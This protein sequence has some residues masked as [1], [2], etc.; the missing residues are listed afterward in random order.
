MDETIT[1]FYYE[2]I[3]AQI[4]FYENLL[5]LEKTMD[6]DWVKIYRITTSSSVGIVQQG[7]GYHDVSA[8]KPAMLSIVTENVDAWYERLVEAEVHV[9]KELPVLGNDKESGHAPVRGFLVEDPGGYTIEFF[10]WQKTPQ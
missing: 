6:E 3:E 9:L 2:D 8:D 5:G 7:H 4:P 1:F 10:S